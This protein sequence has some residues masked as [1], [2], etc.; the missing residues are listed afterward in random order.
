[1]AIVQNPLIGK[2]SGSIGNTIFQVQY[3]KN[4]IRNKP[5]HV[6]P[7]DSL[8]RLLCR[9]KM[10]EINKFVRF[11]RLALQSYAPAS[12]KTSPFVSYIISTFM[13][14]LEAPNLEPE[15]I[16]DENNILGGGRPF[17]HRAGFFSTSWNNGRF[18]AESRIA[19]I[20]E[21]EIDE[22]NKFNAIVFDDRLQVLMM[23]SE[24]IYNKNQNQFE[25][26][27]PQ[28]IYEP[29]KYFI[30]TIRNEANSRGEYPADY[31]LPRTKSDCNNFFLFSS[32]ALII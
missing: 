16:I 14:N 30:I 10:Q 22:E 20:S 27:A 2:S 8:P 32:V 4:T 28:E 17:F 24:A 23:T 26:D 12:L 15:F 6:T 11:A 13:N 19:E 9:H 29:N 7:N 25:F 5:L 1:M 21:Y 31:L 18:Y 3:Q